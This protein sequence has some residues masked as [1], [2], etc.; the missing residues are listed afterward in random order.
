MRLARLVVFTPAEASELL[1]VA[2]LFGRAEAAGVCRELGG[3]LPCATPFRD[4]YA[5]FRELWRE[6]EGCA[7][8]A[9][10]VLAARSDFSEPVLKNLYLKLCKSETRR[11]K[12]R[13]AAAKKPA[14]DSRAK[15]CTLL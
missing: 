5:S 3:C 1:L 10:P 6:Y 4:L 15:T 12:A 11:E 9:H 2:L 7:R 13:T 8:E 14:Y